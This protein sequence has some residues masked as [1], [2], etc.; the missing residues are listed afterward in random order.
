M[1]IKI[2]AAQSKIRL[3]VL[4]KNLSEL[5]KNVFNFASVWVYICDYTCQNHHCINY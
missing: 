3:D 4:I 2:S 1:T 5:E